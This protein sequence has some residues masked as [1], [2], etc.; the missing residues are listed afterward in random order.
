MQR[1]SQRPTKHEGLRT[2]VLLL[3]VRRQAASERRSILPA[4][5]K[6]NTYRFRT[7][8]EPV[9]ELRLQEPRGLNSIKPQG[10]KEILT[11]QLSCPV[12]LRRKWE[13]GKKS[14]E[15]LANSR[16]PNGGWRSGWEFRAQGMIKL[17]SP[18]SAAFA[19]APEGATSSYWWR[20]DVRHH[21]LLQTPS[22]GKRSR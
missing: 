12:G 1:S 19:A 22:P 6:P 10:S 18:P 5:K 15:M 2:S 3:L 21:P 11:P 20:T 8:L 14:A 16:R 7:L 9:C 17:T 13:C 4:R